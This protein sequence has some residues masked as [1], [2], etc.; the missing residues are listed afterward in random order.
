MKVKELTKISLMLIL[1]SPLLV[2]ETQAEFGAKVQQFP[3]FAIGGGVTTSFTIHKPDAV[4]IPI[5]VNIQLYRSNGTLFLT[6]QVVLGL[7]LIHI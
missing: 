1:L 2:S 4:S 7:S 6:D 3:H 5:T